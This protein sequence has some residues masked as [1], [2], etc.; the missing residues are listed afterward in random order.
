MGIVIGIPFI[1]VCWAMWAL[2]QPEPLPTFLQLFETR[3]TLVAGTGY[4]WGE[5]N[6]VGGYRVYAIH[7]PAE[8]ILPTFQKLGKLTSLYFT[9]GAS[10]ASRRFNGIP[11]QLESGNEDPLN[12]YSL[13]PARPVIDRGLVSESTAAEGWSTVIVLWHRPFGPLE[14]LMQWGHL[15]WLDWKYGKEKSVLYIKDRTSKL[16]QL[17]NQEHPEPENTLDEVPNDRPGLTDP[18]TR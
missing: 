17:W 2:G 6:S 12:Q 3:T 11:I 14:R 18:R 7:A 10:S 8:E 16:R 5:P 13:I 1:L 4:P 15:P 9:G